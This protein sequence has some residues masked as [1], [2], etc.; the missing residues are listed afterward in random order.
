MARATEK[1]TKEDEIKKWM[2][3]FAEKYGYRKTELEKGFEFFCLHA[4]ASQHHFVSLFEGNDIN[5]P[6]L[7]EWYCGG[8]NDG[9][10]DGVLHS[11]EENRVAIIQSKKRDRSLNSQDLDDARSFFN[12]LDAWTNRTKRKKLNKH[13]SDLLD[14][15]ALNPRKQTIELWYMISASSTDDASKAHLE[16][17]INE[18]YQKYNGN[19]TAHFLTRSDILTLWRQGVEQGAPSRVGNLTFSVEKKN[20]LIYEPNEVRV[21]ICAIKANEIVSLYK[22]RGVQAN[23]FNSNI[24]LALDNVKVNRTMTDTAKDPEQAPYFFVYNN[25]ITATCQDFKVDGTKVTTEGLQIVNGAQTVASLVRAYNEQPNLKAYVLLRVIE[26]QEKYGKKNE[27]AD[28]IALYQNTQNAV[29]ISDFF[30]NEQPQG[31]L[32]QTLD[33]YSGKFDIPPFFYEHKRGAKKLPGKIRLSIEDL[34]YLRYAC[35][36]DAP[37]TYK[38]AKDI[39]QQDNK[40]N[41]WV[42]FGED[43]DPAALWNDESLEQALWMIRTWLNLRGKQKKEI[44]LKDPKD[45]QLQY[46]GVLAR[47]A[48]AIAFRAA[49]ELQ[50]KGQM[51]DFSDL[52]RKPNSEKEGLLLRSV[53]NELRRT[54]E[55]WQKEKSQANVR[56]NLAQSQEAFHEILKESL[57]F[58]ELLK[59][60]KGD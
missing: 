12:S 49:S 16:N 2:Q 48:T 37:F 34:G 20:F 52:L 5:D 27:L 9:D 46:I 55:T 28:K 21:L 8:P 6:M 13:V 26:T 51:D 50:A 59:A 11:P 24:R 7:S 60:N 1:S 18:Q 32:A 36:K 41:Y 17:E 44:K 3:V 57:R 15:V 58:Y 31:W 47:F 53:L 10:I 14:T 23:L 30:S 22:H 33:K 54:Y 29:R 25:G 19:V 56:L 4:V 45:V 40:E 43:G 42:A 39:W 35:L 38:T